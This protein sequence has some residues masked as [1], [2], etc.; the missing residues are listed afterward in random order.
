MS[1]VQR[2][3]VERGICLV[4]MIAYT[5]AV[6]WLHYKQICAP[7]GGDD[8]YPSDLGLHLKYAKDGMIYSTALL[9]VYQFYALGGL[10]GIAVL[11][12]VFHL[13]AIAIF[14]WGLHYATP[15]LSK[16]ICVLV[17]LTSYLCQAV[18]VPKG[19]NWYGGTITGVIYHN[20]TYIMMAPLALLAVFIF[21]RVW[22]SVNDR[23]LNRRAWVAYTILLTLA[24][25]F[26]A[27]FVF[28]FAP[29]LLLL[30]VANLIHTHGKNLKNEI[31][32]GC[33]VLPSVALCLLQA[34]VLFADEDGGLHFI[35]A[36]DFDPDK[37]AW[38]LFN[39]AAI[40][41]LFRSFVFV[42]LVGIVFKNVVWKNFRYRFGLLLL[43]VAMSEALLLVE[44]GDRLYHGNLW[45]G[46]F[47][48]F[49][50]FM[51]ESV[52]V[53]LQE[54]VKWFKGERKAHLSLR[55]LICTIAFL[56]H[57]I[58]GVFYL[59]MLMRGLPYGLPI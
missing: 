26:K 52:S 14:A 49:W 31:V 38:G 3:R 45:W 41:G 30:L 43:C 32:M 8:P 54:C 15:Q 44:S 6:L 12:T 22:R 40:L 24:T 57:V 17:S 50:V 19:G 37:M 4:I 10:L 48:C 7:G 25:S 18:W 9:L 46:P 56:W 21:Y 33:S 1:Q 13:M 47:I 29:T 42:F 20:T 11:L 35:F 34:K 27:N 39:R 28:A 51:L 59:I 53:Y 5:I 23:I 55:L 36:V 2:R 16:S 58:S